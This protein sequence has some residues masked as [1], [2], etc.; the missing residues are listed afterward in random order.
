MAWV[1]GEGEGFRYLTGV[2]VAS[3]DGLPDDLSAVRLP[4]NTYAVFRH[5]GHVSTIRSTC[6]HVHEWLPKSGFEHA[7]T[8]SFFE[9]YGE[10][11]N[12]HTGLGDIEG[13]TA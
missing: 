12:P 5:P 3:T 9:R 13:W 2:E 7:G 11:F 8:P 1:F 10:G 6:Q 4:A